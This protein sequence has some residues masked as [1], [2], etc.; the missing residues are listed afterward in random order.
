MAMD[1]AAEFVQFSED[2]NQ[3]RVGGELER[4]GELF[5]QEAWDKLPSCAVK[6]DILNQLES[7]YKADPKELP[8]NETNTRVLR[9]E[10]GNV[11][12][13]WFDWT[14]IRFPLLGTHQNSAGVIDPLRGC[15]K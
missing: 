7:G 4:I 1:N 3:T 15:S 14:S 5:L 2:V 11:T 9:D 10:N 12:A 6:E 8:E 13:L